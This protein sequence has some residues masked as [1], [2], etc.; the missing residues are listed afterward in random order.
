MSLFAK[1][2]ESENARIKAIDDREKS[3]PL[4]IVNDLVV[5]A[6]RLSAERGRVIDDGSDCCVMVCSPDPVQGWSVEQ[7]LGEVAKRFAENLRAYDSIF[8]HGRDKILVCLPFVKH[9][10][11]TSVMERLRDLANRM[12][13]TL[14][15][16]TSG[17]ITI[18]VGGVM[19]D[20][21]TEVQKIMNRADQAMEQGR[22]SGIRTCMWSLEM[23]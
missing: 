20:R 19:M 21:V 23:L 10:D 3:G 13:V 9:D 6:A 11:T 4:P 17:H 5:L 2:A 15:G 22:L 7:A 1:S 18:S 16:G 8:L 12:P 14:P